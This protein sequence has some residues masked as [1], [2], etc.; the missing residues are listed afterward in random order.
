[1][2]II[3]TPM[4]SKILEFAGISNFKINKNPDEE[5][6]DLAIL[7]SESKVKMNSLKIKLNTFN[8][9]KQSIID[10]SKYSSKGII[11]EDEINNVFSNYPIAMKWLNSNNEIKEKNSKISIKVYSEFLKDIVKDMNFNL[12]SVEYDYVVFPDYMGNLV[13][14][15][16][17]NKLISIPTHNNI[18]KDP[19]KRGEIRYSILENI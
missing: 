6:G 12:N 8:Q 1:M 3:T 9:I 7:L 17:E 11:T 18:S 15:H 5:E 16:D 14:E 10:V 19:I 13:E 4:C 2:I